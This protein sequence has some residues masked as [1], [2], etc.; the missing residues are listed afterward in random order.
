MKYIR[1]VDNFFINIIPDL[2]ANVNGPN[3]MA[4][5]TY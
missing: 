1:Q 3:E 2:S 5:F 4:V